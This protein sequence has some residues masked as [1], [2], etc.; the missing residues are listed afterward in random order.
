MKKVFK[1]RLNPTAK[2]RR[3][4]EL[5][6]ETLRQFYNA[7]LEERRSAW[8]WC[9]K[10]IGYLVQANQLKEI[11]REHPEL[12]AVNYSATQD[13]LRRLQKAFDAFF[14]RIKAGEKP[15][16]PRFKGENRYDSITFPSYGDGIRYQHGRLYVQGIVRIKIK[17]HRPVVRRIKTVTIKREGWKWYAV[18]TV[19]Y[20]PGANG[21]PVPVSPIGLDVNLENF[22]TTSDGAVVGNP[23]WYRHSEKMLTWCGRLVSRK[24]KG[25]NRRKKALVRLQNWH[26]KVKNQRRDF[27]H[28]LSRRLLNDNDAVFF[29]D[30]NIA[31]MVKNHCLAKSIAD[32]GWGQFLAMISY[33][34]AE[35][36][37][38]SLAVAPHWTTQQCSGCGA[39]V[40]KGLSQR[41]HACP[42]CG[43]QLPRDHNSALNI[44]A[45]G[46]TVVARGESA[47]AGSLNRETVSGCV[48]TLP[49]A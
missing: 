41:R 10:S 19:E 15:G 7:A 29:E 40:M 2:Q 1:Y 45:V 38:L 4:L 17:P 39:L 16:Y 37:K 32:V 46:L 3:S 6:L 34:A 48:H 43:R 47:L 5:Q 27:Q 44:L 14:R 31:G 18:V 12:A 11:R 23:R 49:L 8:K 42:V 26:A 20:E 35:A 25:S 33:K 13:G 36:G 22:L 28:K 24:K 9:Q 30:L 21:Q